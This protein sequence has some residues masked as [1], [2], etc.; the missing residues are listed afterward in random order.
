MDS[1]AELG[2]RFNHNFDTLGRDTDD[3]VK[4][5]TALGER[6]VS[7]GEQFKRQRLLRRR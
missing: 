5:S 3:F 4:A 2:I 7:Y 6:I 1:A